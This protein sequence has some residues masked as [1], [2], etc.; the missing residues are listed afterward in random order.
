M[1]DKQ[2]PKP[3][4]REPSDAPNVPDETN[5]AKDAKAPP[6]TKTGEERSAPGST[7]RPAVTSSADSDEQDNLTHLSPLLAKFE[8]FPGL[9]EQDQKFPGYK[10]QRKAFAPLP[11]PVTL[12][13]PSDLTMW[14]QGVDPTGRQ[15]QQQLFG[16]MRALLFEQTGVHVPAIHVE[17]E[18]SRTPGTF[19][20]FVFETM[21]ATGFARRDHLLVAELPNRLEL[22]G[23]KPEPAFHPTWHR[24]AS[25]VHREH[26]H[27]FHKHPTPTWDCGEYIAMVLGYLLRQHAHEFV[28]IQETSVLLDQLA[29]EYPTLVEEV[30]QTAS[31]PQL[32]RI[33][34]SLVRD[35]VSLFQLRH[36]LEALLDVE[37]DT[38][39][40]NE[41]VDAIRRQ[42][43]HHLCY[44]YLQNEQLL[45][46]TVSPGLEDKLLTFFEEQ[47]SGESMPPERV[48]ERR[49]LWDQ[50]LQL[51]GQQLEQIP[52][53]TPITPVLLVQKHRLR[54]PLQRLVHARYPW[55]N[56]LSMQEIPPIYPVNPMAVL[57]L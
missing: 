9:E 39:D 8:V 54:R 35:R 36:V 16:E 5:K 34:R 32:R 15:V 30:L 55:I 49:Q 40:L 14:T 26:S 12:Q 1:S 23:L 53:T 46:Y 13:V 18:K 33:L 24:P 11:R 45:V 41:I 42:L 2:P 3:P 31:R 10:H 21:V 56:A 37:T 20:L 28:G 50:V 7:K 48:V 17:V 44:P 38:H 47:S 43:Q 25:W 57:N 27:L 6:E 4:S 51:L 29:L 22:L 52:G 19:A